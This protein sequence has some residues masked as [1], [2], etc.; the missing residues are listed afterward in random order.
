MAGCLTILLFGAISNI[1]DR[2]RLGFVIDYID[3]KYFTIF[4]IADI[5]IVGSIGLLI[6]TNI[7]NH[8]RL[9]SQREQK[10]KKGE[11]NETLER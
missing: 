5:M 8:S 6:I 7:K 9:E 3:L 1:I 4:N 11:V 10:E 2:I